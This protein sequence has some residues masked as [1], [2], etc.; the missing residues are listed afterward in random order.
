MEAN[1]HFGSISTLARDFWYL[2][3]WTDRQVSPAQL[4]PLHFGP[5]TLRLK[6][7]WPVTFWLLAFSLFYPNRDV[8]TGTTD[9][10]AVAPKFSDVLTLF[11]PGGQILPYHCR[12]RTINFPAVTSLGTIP[13]YS[14]SILK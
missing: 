8:T 3:L 6:T 9:K 12:G 7:F 14:D 10:T 1:P 13:R 4:S 2:T 5:C 11:Q